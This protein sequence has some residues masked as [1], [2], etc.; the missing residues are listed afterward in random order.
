MVTPQVP[1]VSVQNSEGKP[2]S[3]HQGGQ[4]P[5]EESMQEEP[6]VGTAANP[7]YTELGSNLGTKPF[8]EWQVLD[9]FG[10]KDDS[11]NQ[12]KTER[13]L[14]VIYH[15]LSAF[16]EMQDDV[17]ATQTAQT[18]THSASSPLS[19]QQQ[20]DEA[21]HSGQTF[22]N[23]VSG[24]GKPSISVAGKSAKDVDDLTYE[25]Q[26]A[27]PSTDEVVEQRLR[28]TSVELFNFYM[29]Q[30]HEPNL[31]AIQLFWGLLYEVIVRYLSQPAFSKLMF[32]PRKLISRYQFF[33]RRFRR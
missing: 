6:P 31:P 28:K 23:R 33:F 14:L 13:F 15:S 22:I 16:C 20:H 7:A 24:N 3:E 30:D 10:I 21:S 32:Y 27:A 26:K 4:E 25:L 11:S 9:D 19:D 2:I 1:A 12:V 8:L 5:S 29:P 18:T 17:E